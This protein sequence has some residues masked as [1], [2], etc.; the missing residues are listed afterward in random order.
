MLDSD[1]QSM[2]A[3]QAQRAANTSKRARILVVEDHSIDQK[4]AVLML[5][6][7]GYNADLASNGCEA[8]DLLAFQRYDL[9]LM[10]C[11]MPG[12]DGFEATR[13]I[14]ANSAY[15]AKLPIIAV[16]AG[17]IT[18]NRAAC[19]ISGMNDYL[20]KP[21]RAPELSAKLEFWLSR[22]AC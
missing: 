17:A 11:Q 2:T 4:V 8:V 10:D 16:T 1:L 13:H 6:S 5:K 7:L 15:G 21:M 9:V 22:P 20:S 19:L 18:Q 14:R 3:P 12:M